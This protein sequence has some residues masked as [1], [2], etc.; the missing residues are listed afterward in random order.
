M[1]ILINASNLKAGG[2]LQV[3]D[4]ICREIHKFQQHE[5]TVVL[6]SYLYDTFE[7]LKEVSNIKLYRYD[8]KNSISTIV[9]GREP[10][11]DGLVNNNS[12]E[13]V[14]TI[15]GPSRWN[16]RIPHLS[17]FA[18]SQILVPESPYFKILRRIDRIKYGIYNR[19]LE[20]AFKRSGK[21]FYTENP[22]ISERLKKLFP[23]KTVYTVT[24][25]YNQIFDNPSQW[26]EIKLP[27]FDGVTLLTIATPYIHKNV[28]IAA[29]TARFLRKK[30]PD[31][32]FRFV[33][34]FDKEDFHA[35]IKNIEENFLFIGR[36]DIS[37]CP[38]LYMQCDIV[39]V[40]TLIECF[41]AAYPEAMRMRKPIVTTDLEF[42]HG[43]CGDAAVYYSALDSQDCANAIYR[44]ASD[45]S[46]RT[47][48][49][50]NGEE[51][52]NHYDDYSQRAMKLV[53][54]TAA[55]R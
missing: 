42:A 8:I 51:Q 53:E 28:T 39:F 13:T 49:V 36:V 43:L 15:F 54:L 47:I 45:D 33:F 18:I 2:G 3:A 14:L 30:Y 27:S 40:P 1:N 5:F 32:R 17:G 25:Y 52:L 37:E 22:F 44:V 50:K 41:T 26:R 24:N 7:A 35:D 29:S 34:S 6:S 46:I 9:F 12:I 55:L 23:D 31:F 20:I 19:L 48:M 16:P 11:L 38:S 21:Y 4:S 10:F